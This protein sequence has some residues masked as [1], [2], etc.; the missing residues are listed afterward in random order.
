MKIVFVLGSVGMSGGNYVTCQH[1]VHAASMGHEVTLAVMSRF[2]T[3]NHDW[4]PGFASLRIV[5]LDDLG[6]QRFDLAIATF[7]K[8]AL[9]LHRIDAAQYAY[10]VQSIESRF[11]DESLPRHRALVERTYGLGL[12]GVTEA[13]WIR[14][15]LAQHHA[16]DFLLAHN[17]IRKDL[18]TQDGPCHSPRVPGKLRVLVEGGFGA[19][20]KNTAR[21]VRTA[22]RAR[23]HES[24]LMTNTQMTWYPGVNRLFSQ[25]PITDVGRVYRSCDVIVKLSLVEG[26]FGPPLEMFHCGGTAV[27]YDVSGHDEYIV[28]G[29]NALVAKMHDEAAVV[30]HLKELRDSPRRLAE[31]KAGAIQTA[32]DW[33]DW[34][35]SSALFVRHIEAL[36]EA[37]PVSREA[38][39]E[40]TLAIRAE[41]APLLN[42]A[43]GAAPASAAPGGLRA[44]LGA[45]RETV[46]GYKRLLGHIREGYQ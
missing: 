10:F 7:W 18:Y 12:P 5:Q 13:T 14:D 38:L 44:R 40:Q 1:A 43:P 46:R 42:A 23:P 9:E 45:V 6:M 41:F 36:R 32:A 21:T 15:Y 20:F 29:R 24:W 22:R 39:R 17:G 26:M 37:A 27:V 2:T 4:H 8:T 16:S 31:L 19:P 34:G 28:H 30:E 25:V 35:E 3:A 11:F 33:P